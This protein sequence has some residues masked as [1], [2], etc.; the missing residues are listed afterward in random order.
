MSGHWR[1]I[2]A[3]ISRRTYAERSRPVGTFESSPVR[4]A[5]LAFR[6]SDPSRM[7]RST[8]AYTLEAACERSEAERFYRPWR[9]EHLFFASFPRSS[10]WASFIGSLRDGFLLQTSSGWHPNVEAS[11]FISSAPAIVPSQSLDSHE[12]AGF[13]R[14]WSKIDRRSSKRPGKKG[15][16]PSFASDVSCV[17]GCRGDSVARHSSF[18]TWSRLG[19]GDRLR[20]SHLDQDQV[21]LSSQPPVFPGLLDEGSL[22]YSSDIV[23]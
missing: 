19:V 7:G 20:G 12:S 15:G 5:G 21:S 9:D 4:S 10:Y 22:A 23:R 18:K 13:E 14:F 8:A 16:Y 2:R 17:P 1:H 6:K 3:N 11:P